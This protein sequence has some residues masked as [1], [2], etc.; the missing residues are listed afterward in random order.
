MYKNLMRFFLVYKNILKL[1]LIYVLLGN[2]FSLLYLD[3][4][5]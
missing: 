5:V 2:R 1:Y 4:D 3:C